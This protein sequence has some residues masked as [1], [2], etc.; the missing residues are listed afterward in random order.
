MD[1]YVKITKEFGT[2]YV[3]QGVSLLTA[4]LLFSLLTRHLSVKEFGFYSIILVSLNLMLGMMNM[5]LP[6]FIQRDLT[7]RT[8]KYKHKKFSTINTFYM[9]MIAVYIVAFLIFQL[10][11]QNLVDKA[12]VTYL[13]IS[14]IFA[15]YSSLFASY[16]LSRTELIKS[17]ILSY[18][19]ADSWYLLVIIYAAI[20]K[21]LNI[22]RIFLIKAMAVLLATAIVLTIIKDKKR[23]FRLNID[24][25]Y[26]IKALQYG[27]P[28]IPILIA[29]WVITASDRYL[30]KI[31]ETNLEV[32]YYA[33]IYS[34]VVFVSMAGKQI[35]STLT[36]YMI[37]ASNQKK[38][39]GML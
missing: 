19:I 33:Y 34:L 26:L 2:G 18:L 37:E 39:A 8:D 25:N 17:K 31:F 29:Q 13:F 35:S 21:T 32:G 3:L 1:K 10:F 22:N 28:F 15:Y 14:L 23:L 5:G 16:L 6:N 9:I 12:L 20:F 4:F 27:L 36:T 30:I 24:Q 7:G 11:N 38:I